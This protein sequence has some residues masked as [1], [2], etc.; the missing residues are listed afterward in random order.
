MK[1][2]NIKQAEF[3]TRKNRFV[4]EI[5]LDGNIHSC[6]VKNTGRL[7]ELLV[8]G[9]MVFV[10]E[11]DNPERKTRYSLIAVEKKDGVVNI[12][13]QAPNK[14]FYE[15]VS[16]GGFGKDVTLIKPETVYGNSRFDCYIEVGSRR[17]FV[18]VKGVT[19]ENDGRALFPDAPTERGVKHLLELCECV[20]NGF[21]AYIVFVIQMKGVHIFSPNRNMHREFAEALE[22]CSRCGVNILC[23]DC[24]VTPD[25]LEISQSIDYEL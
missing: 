3:V 10:E 2:K 16:K 8:A 7:K 22:K 13:S 6:H 20:K 4:A 9:A 15:W 24:N 18:E 25:S 17:I 1:Y 23:V 5:R 14:V 21:E 12:D 11:T 19:L